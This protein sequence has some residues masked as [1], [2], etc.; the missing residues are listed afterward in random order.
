MQAQLPNRACIKEI[1]VVLNHLFQKI[2][3]F[4]PKQWLLWPLLRYKHW[5][6]INVRRRWQRQGQPGMILKTTVNYYS[7]P[8]SWT[9]SIVLR[10][11]VVAELGKNDGCTPGVMSVRFSSK[12]YRKRRRFSAISSSGSDQEIYADCWFICPSW[13]WITTLYFTNVIDID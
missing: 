6:S 11:E 1:P 7:Q 3:S 13:G 4:V 2:Q 12:E 9:I 5:Q 10:R 8:N